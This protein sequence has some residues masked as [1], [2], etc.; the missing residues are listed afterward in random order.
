MR[1]SAALARGWAWDGAGQCA[2]L[3]IDPNQFDV[4]VAHPGRW[5]AE[6]APVGMDVGLDDG[7]R[8]LGD[9]TAQGMTQHSTS[10]SQHSHRSQFFLVL[11]HSTG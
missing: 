8:G 4:E 10:Q 9:D 5:L 1:K 2:K 6:V 11:S 7:A 3:G